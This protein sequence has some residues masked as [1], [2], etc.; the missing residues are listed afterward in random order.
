MSFRRSIVVWY[1][2]YAN[3]SRN[4]SFYLPERAKWSK[5]IKAYS[6]EEP[7][8]CNTAVPL[9]NSAVLAS[10]LERLFGT[11]HIYLRAKGPCIGC[12]FSFSD[13]FD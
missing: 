4:M 2:V 5:I 1:L 7:A 13:I 6:S 11:N 9:T 8:E 12:P 3:L 10:Y